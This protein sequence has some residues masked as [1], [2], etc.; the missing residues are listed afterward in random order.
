[1]KEKCIKM[2][3]SDVLFDFLRWFKNRV[4]R[5]KGDYDYQAGIAYSVPGTLRLFVDVPFHCWNF[6][7]SP[8]LQRFTNV[9]SPKYVFKQFKADIRRGYIRFYFERRNFVVIYN[10]QVVIDEC[11]ESDLPF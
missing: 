8:T 9:S 1:M 3:P 4:G 11:I 10:H 7:G 2:R 6:F 5:V